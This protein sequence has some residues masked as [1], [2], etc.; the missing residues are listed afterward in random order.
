MSFLKL[1]PEQKRERKRE[2]YK[3]WLKRSKKQGV[4]L[5]E[6][7]EELASKYLYKNQKVVEQ[8]II[9]IEKN[10]KNN[11]TNYNHGTKGERA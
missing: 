7:R 1:S 8:T 6:L 4:I 3:E 5:Y 9:R 2:M 10:K 11:G